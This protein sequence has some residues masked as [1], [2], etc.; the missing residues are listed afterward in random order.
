[1]RISLMTNPGVLD[2]FSSFGYVSSV[3]EPHSSLISIDS[4]TTIILIR[5]LQNCVPFISSLMAM[6][7]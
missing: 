5:K 3:I 6:T 7:V 2:D 1:M 4:L